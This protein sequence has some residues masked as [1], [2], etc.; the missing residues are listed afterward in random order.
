M[1]D[2]QKTLVKAFKALPKRDRERLRFHAEKKTPI[3][4]G[5]DCG[6]YVFRGGA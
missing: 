2:A 6:W 3:C 4:C 1:T 5:E